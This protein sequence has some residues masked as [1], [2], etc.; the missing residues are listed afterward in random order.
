[1]WVIH[2]RLAE[3]YFI[4]EKRPFTEQEE[5]DFLDCL[6]ANANRA[7][8]LAKL[9]NLSLLAS[10]TNDTEWQHEICSAIDKLQVE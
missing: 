1:M 10:L 6:K 3:L 9:Q 8:K 7:W 5:R 2:Q 4:N